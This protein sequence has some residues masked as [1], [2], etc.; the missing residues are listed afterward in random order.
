ML[1]KRVLSILIAC[2]LGFFPAP[3][4]LSK[5]MLKLAVDVWAP[6]ENI[7]NK[8]A[9]GFSTEVVTSVLR[10][11]GAQWDIK[12][13]PWARALKE[14]FE[15]NRD[16]LFTAFWTEER[17]RYCYY[18][19]EP[20]AKERWVFFVRRKD[21]PRLSFSS[22][23]EIKTRRIGI[24]RGASV[25]EEFWDFVEAHKNYDEV[26]TD[27]LNFKKL[28]RGRIDYVV[29]SYSNGVEL[30]KQM[31]I[32]DEI[33]FLPSPVITEDDLFIVFSKKSVSPAFVEKF[34]DALR[35]FKKSDE[36][37]VIYRKYFELP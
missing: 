16:A 27:D 37:N 10:E 32:S 36:F 9:P 34:S 12:E 35:V 3:Y 28:L 15:G 33:A 19:K 23:D 11:I 1:R 26:A 24:L 4:A 22:Y 2:L 6:Y 29:T 5:D 30:A 18:P 7:S 13:Y 8:E 20:L 17:A 21:V 25:T 14:V 31:D